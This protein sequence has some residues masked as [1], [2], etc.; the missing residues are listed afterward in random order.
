MLAA[1]PLGAWPTDAAAPPPRRTADW[2]RGRRRSASRA[3]AGAHPR[4]CRAAF[5]FK[6]RDRHVCPASSVSV[7]HDTTQR[8]RLVFPTFAR[9]S[10]RP[11]ASPGVVGE[12]RD[13]SPRHDGR[14]GPVFTHS[15]TTTQSPPRRQAASSPST[16]QAR[17][18]RCPP[19]TSSLRGGPGAPL[20]LLTTRWPLGAATAV[21]A[22]PSSGTTLWQPRA[23]V[24]PQQARGE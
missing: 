23:T 11:S 21:F 12:Q 3:H 1:F 17:R 2:L 18:P 14:G 20:C 19:P 22:S 7:R 16:Q 13:S 9:Q 6:H 5:S 24:R 15:D 8:R 10:A 4:Q